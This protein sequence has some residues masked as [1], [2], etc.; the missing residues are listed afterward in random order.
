MYCSVSGAGKIKL[1]KTLKKVTNSFEGKTSL[2]FRM[3]LTHLSNNSCE[4]RASHPTSYLIKTRN[5]LIER[6]IVYKD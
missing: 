2:N 3:I 5:R 1:A 6:K 4:F